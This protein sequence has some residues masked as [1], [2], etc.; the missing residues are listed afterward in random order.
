MSNQTTTPD[1]EQDK[2]SG[3]PDK[4]GLFVVCNGAECVCDKSNE[5]T[6]ATLKV[7]SQTKIYVNDKDGAEKLVANT[8]DLGIPFEV[9]VQTFGTCKMQPTGTSY[10]PCIPNIVQWKDPYEAIV[11]DNMGQALVDDSEGTCAFGGKITFET[12]GQTETVSQQDAEAA[13]NDIATVVN[14]ALS[15]EDIHE[16]IA[17]QFTTNTEDEKGA[18]VKRIATE[19]DKYAYHFTKPDISFNVKQYSSKNPTEAQKAGINWAVFYKGEKDK[20]YKEVGKY[21]DIGEHFDF[22]FQTQ[23][24][25][26]VEAYGGKKGPYFIKKKSLAAYKKI[27]LASQKLKGIYGPFVGS[28]DRSQYKRVRPDE[29]VTIKANLLFDQKDLKTALSGKKHMQGV[30]WEAKAY[31]NK[32]DIPVEIIKDKNNPKQIT[33]APLGKNAKVTVTATNPNTG[34][35]STVKYTVGSNYVIRIKANKETIS[36]WDGKEQKKERHQVTLEVDKYVIEP[37]RQAEKDAVQW[38]SFCKG[39]KPNTDKVIATGHSTVQVLQEEAEMIYEAYGIRPSGGESQSAKKVTGI[40][41]KITK[42]YWADK[43][44]NKIHRSGFEHEVYIHIETEGLTGEKLKLNV[45][46]SDQNSA[47]DYVKNAGT[48][49][50]IKA[51][52]GVIHQAFTLPESHYLE[53]EYFFTIQELP[54]IVQGTKQDNGCNNEYVLWANWTDKKTHY[55]YV[56]KDKKIVSLR[57]YE[58]GDKLHTGIIKYGDCV[59]VKVETRNYVDQTLTFKIYEDINWA[60]DPEKDETIS[61]PIDSQG[62]GEAQF[63]VPTA[64]E[65]DHKDA[66]I[67][68]YFYLEYDGEEFPRSFYIKSK[69]KEENEV[70]SKPRVRALML[71]V[72]TTLEL[73]EQL[74]ADNA[75]VLGAELTVNGQGDCKGKYCIKLGEESQLIQEINIRLAGFGGNVPTKKFTTKTVAMIQQFQ[76]DF[77]EVEPTGKICG[78]TLKAIDEFE[79][80]YPINFD[81]IKCKCGKCNGFGQGKFSAQKQDGDIKEKFRKYE[82]PGIH[83]SLLW[84]YKAIMF[85][86][87]KKENAK[88]SINKIKS[89]YRCHEDNKQNSRTTTNHMGKA[90]DIHF[91]KDG[92]RTRELIDVERVRDKVIIPTNKAQI[93]WTAKNLFSVEPSRK[94]YPKEFIA[95]S[96]IHM[97]VRRFELKYLKDEYFADTLDKINGK[98]IV[99]I[100]KEEGFAKTCECI[101]AYASQQ[102]SKSSSKGENYKW[103]H[104]T[105]GNLIAQ[106]ESRNDYNLCNQTK[107]GLKEI[108][109]LTIVK[110]KISEVQI[111]QKNRDIFAVGRYQLI[112]KTLTAAISSLNLDVSK[113]LDEEMQDKI[114]DEYLIDKKRPQIIAYLEGNGSVNDAMYAAAKEWASIGVEKGKKISNIKVKENGKEVLKS[115]VATKGGESY[116]SGDGLNKAHIT[117]EQIKN[118]LINSKNENK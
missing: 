63:M 47:D 75:V 8:N 56:N 115:R 101:G 110:M 73:D 39:E 82:Y 94:T 29:A 26:V 113:N 5:G 15:E 111:K 9:P 107:G 118:V 48:D 99:D 66:C 55:L 34:E 3:K 40:L 59:T 93:R 90:I 44:G 51:Q 38:T 35:T 25:F 23:G 49:I 1:Q 17:G 60:I 50:E 20:K 13:T 68:R 104:S 96:W 32:T 95:T 98:K 54:C 52:N 116:Y 69:G 10:M 4:S 18:S 14:P 102:S 7:L 86:L 103:A 87:T 57:M 36:V 37:A 67:P 72:S 21:P 78:D 100:A 24:T 88:Y 109:N 83:R 22:P 97:D 80:K 85:Y 11:L 112:P 79:A 12:H 65:S 71:K 53:Q 30:V 45:W 46:E 62:K 31:Q 74:E 28:Q 41:P 89:G 81:E 64:W 58:N 117:P 6:K 16:L 42:A 77:M 27:T 92:K 33:I 91:N 70:E 114:F 43:K 106:K 84:A 108:S 61:I 105:F 2:S 19:D 76:R